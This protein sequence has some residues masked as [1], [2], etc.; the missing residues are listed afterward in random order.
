M[1]LPLISFHLN[2]SQTDHQ[3]INQLRKTLVSRVEGH[4]SSSVT[5]TVVPYSSQHLVLCA[6]PGGKSF[7]QGQSQDVLGC[8]HLGPAAISWFPVEGVQ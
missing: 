4:S 3:S 2:P 7:G 6:R 8:Y 1:N 5:V